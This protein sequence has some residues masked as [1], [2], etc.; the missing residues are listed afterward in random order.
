M[1]DAGHAPQTI[2]AQF[3]HSGWVHYVLKSSH[4]QQVQHYWV[5]LIQNYARVKL[6]HLDSA[7]GIT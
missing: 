5:D 3:R 7:P 6:W 1:G 4:P 2:W